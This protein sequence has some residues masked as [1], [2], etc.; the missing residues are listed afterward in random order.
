MAHAWSRPESGRKAVAVWLLGLVLL[1]AVVDATG[2]ESSAPA[3]VRAAFVP[4][5]EGLLL[6][7]LARA[8]QEVRAAVFTFTR[9]GVAEALIEAAARGVDVRL[10]VDADQARDLELMAELMA[11]LRQGR[12]AVEEIRMPSVRY[13]ADMHHKFAVVDGRWVITGSANWTKSAT[14]V[15]WENVL[16]IESPE[17]AARFRREWERIRSRDD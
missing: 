15:N 14:S 8:T 7:H 9:R 13:G 17:L 3:R 10:K 2:A 11:L 16:A 6:E 5:C 4:E 12:V 1:A